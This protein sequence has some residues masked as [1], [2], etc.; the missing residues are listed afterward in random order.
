MHKTDY[1]PHNSPPANSLSE[2]VIHPKWST[3]NPKSTVIRFFQFTMR[4]DISE[5]CDTT[6]SGW[7]YSHLRISLLSYLHNYLSEYCCSALA[8]APV[9]D[10][11]LSWFTIR[12]K[13]ESRGKVKSTHQEVL[14]YL[15]AESVSFRIWLHD[16]VT[17][18]VF[19]SSTSAGFLHDCC[20]LLQLGSN[21]V[22]SCDSALGLTYFLTFSVWNCINILHLI[23]FVKE[24]RSF[25]CL[26]HNYKI[27]SLGGLLWTILILI[28]TSLKTV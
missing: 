28:C 8:L 1:D 4:K 11:G 21:H 2:F 24:I 26:H 6:S 7:M 9:V 25:A 20:V 17:K 27:S 3:N 12:Y 16:G 5:S 18:T 13:F 10:R 14:M 22:S 23:V 15:V 19:L